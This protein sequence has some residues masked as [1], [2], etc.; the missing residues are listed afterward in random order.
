M[1]E[2]KNRKKQPDVVDLRTYREK[3]D[4]KKTAEPSGGG[5]EPSPSPIFVVQKHAARRLHYDLR[6][7]AEGVLKSWAVPK[8]P[9]YDPGEKRLAVQ[10]EDHPLEYADFEGLIPE[11]EY[12]A[13]TVM[14]WDRGAWA[15]VGDWQKGLREGHLKFRLHGK[16]L[17][18]QWT[19]VKMQDRGDEEFG[20]DHRDNWLLIKHPEEQAEHP[21]DFDVTVQE[22][23]SVKTGR[24]MEEITAQKRAFWRG[25]REASRADKKTAAHPATAP[26]APKGTKGPLPESFYPQLATLTEKLP[27]Q[28]P[29]LSEIKF[30]GYRVLARITD[31]RVALFTRRGQ[32]WTEKFSSLARQLSGVPLRNAIIDGEVV[33][34]NPDG[35][36][37]FQKLQNFMKS[38]NEKDLVYYA[39]DLPYY[40]DHDLTRLPLIERKD[41]LQQLLAAFQEKLPSVRYT[42]HIEGSGERI[43]RHACG[44]GIEGIIAKRADSPY[45]QKRA[46]SWVKKKCINRQEFV[47]GGYTTPK[48]TRALF[49]S[50]V[51]GYYNEKRKLIYCGNVGTG[52]NEKM[53]RTVYE[54]LKPLEQEQSPFAAAIFD[55][56]NRD[57]R[58]TAPRLVAEVE[59]SEWTEGGHLRHPSFIALR[60][61]KKPEEIGIEKPAPPPD[62]G[63]PGPDKTGRDHA[64]PSSNDAAPSFSLPLV[65]GRTK[66]GS[67]IPFKLTNPGKLLYPAV[68]K[69]ELAEYYL[70]VGEWMLPEI[71]NRPLVMVRCPEGV[72]EGTRD[73]CFYQKHLR[74]DIPEGIRTAAIEEKGQVG[75]YPVVDDITGILSLVQLGVLEIHMLGCRADAVEHPDRMIFDL[76]PSPDVPAARL[77]EATLYLRNWLAQ[78]KMR[79][80][81]KLTGGK[82]IHI[83][84]PLSP[85]LTWDEV[86]KISKAVAEEMVRTRPDWFVATVTKRKRTG[87]ILVDYLRNGLGASTIVPYSTRANPAATIAFPLA[88][89]ELREELLSRPVTVRDAG[90]RLPELRGNPWEE[91]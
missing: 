87:K 86:K 11:K 49:G 22:P 24:T 58:W 78:N 74:D 35:T 76:D 21:N 63:R 61:D 67:V 85:V 62:T 14:V 9:S 43:L 81:L 37:D 88:D 26:P 28:G 52:F 48:G 75:L 91:S 25:P 13:G 40:Q 17:K 6:L 57:V 51:L 1:A 89:H 90:Q 8:G 69:K 50:L 79:P 3:R 36:T 15:P 29:W 84:V 42:E 5:L 30:D 66:E 20:E 31:G 53:I 60:E 55:P 73:N 65:T 32:D 12:G 64:L 56:R 23:R 54:Q 44:Y 47:I 68:T 46:S 10:V 83:V 33:V 16:K 77:I 27:E 39:F 38:G 19:L 70:R 71:I 7:E 4:F 72:A 34:L 80:F 45:L 41:L 2:R 82:G 59:F 18:G